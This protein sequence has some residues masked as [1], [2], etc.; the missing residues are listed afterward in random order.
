M[1]R[2]AGLSVTCV[3]SLAPIRLLPALVEPLAD[4]GV[5]RVIAFSSTS[6]FT[7]LASA[8]PSERALAQW[9]VGSEE[10]L[11]GA[12]VRRSVAWTVFRPT[13]VYSPGLDR[14]I[15]EIARF[16]RRFGFFPIVADG[17]GKR[18][19]VHA[20]DLAIGCVAALGEPRTFNRAYNLSGG[21]T[22]TYREMVERVFVGL[23][24]RP[25][26]LGI[27]LGVLKAVVHTARIVPRF[28]KL[29]AELV[30][31]MNADMCFDHS[32]A[33]RDFGF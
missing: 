9:L 27:P 11:A 30:T 32:Q 18:E 6:R 33:S 14:N 31:R 5:T 25:R 15:S 2:R 29:S 19:P 7:K 1:L 22:L 16:I 13:L 17:R 4:I 23:G 12:C 21:E 26:I 20:D 8:D 24:R 28:R 3:I 10:A